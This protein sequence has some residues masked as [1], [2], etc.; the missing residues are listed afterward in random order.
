MA[1]V[2][3]VKSDLVGG[4]SRSVEVRE[5][6]TFEDFIG[7]IGNKEAKATYKIEVMFSKHRSSLAHKPSPAMV[8][9][10][11]SGKRYHGGGDER[12]YWCG[13]NDC[14]MPISAD[15][16]AAYHCVCPSCQ[17]ELFLDEVSKGQHTA[18]LIADGRPTRDIDRIKIIGGEKLVNLTPPKLAKLLEVTWR[19]LNGDADI[20]LKYSPHE[21][22]YDPKFETTETIDNLDK[23]R[24]QRQPLIYTLKAIMKDLHAGADLRKRFLTMITD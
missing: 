9:L 6:E 20:Y 23:V 15:N 4:S 13:Y 5:G 16:F 22:R 18:Q 11:E 8:L 19:K 3:T 10:W 7:R 12:M 17:R 24:V 1:E 21:I 14:D 2:K